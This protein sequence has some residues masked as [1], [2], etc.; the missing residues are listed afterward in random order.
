MARPSTLENRILAVVDETR[1]RRPA[2]R[3]AMRAGALGVACVIGASAGAQ[4][5]PAAE[6]LLTAAQFPAALK[7][8]TDKKGA[9][10]LSTPSFITRSKQHAM[11]EIIREF[12]YFVTASIIQLN[13]TT[14]ERPR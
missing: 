4:V 8:L 1:N 7:T 12:R 11:I 3:L 13:G 6:R 10:T 9:N 5:R 2:G 14:I